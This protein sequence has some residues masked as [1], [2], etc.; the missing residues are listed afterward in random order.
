VQEAL[1]NARRHAEARNVLVRL[2]HRDRDGW[3]LVIEDD[4]RGFGFEGRLGPQEL[5]AQRKGPLVIRERARS[6]GGELMIESS[7]GSG[8]RLEVRFPEN[9]ND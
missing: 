9:V 1:V 6:A 7:P 2:D 3:R 8:S 4:G 5:D